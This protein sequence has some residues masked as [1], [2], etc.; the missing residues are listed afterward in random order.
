MSDTVHSQQAG[1]KD[2]TEELNKE[3]AFSHKRKQKK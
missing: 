1:V 2:L 3:V